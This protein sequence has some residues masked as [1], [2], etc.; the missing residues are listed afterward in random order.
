MP[1]IGIQ[2]PLTKPA[3]QPNQG[4]PGGSKNGTASAMKISIASLMPS[5]R[6]PQQSSHPQPWRAGLAVPAR[7]PR[8]A[9][10]HCPP[11]RIDAMRMGTLVRGRAGFPSDV[12]AGWEAMRMPLAGVTGRGSLVERHPGPRLVPHG[13]SRETAP[14][15]PRVPRRKPRNGYQA[16]AW[17][18]P[19][20][21]DQNPG[22]SLPP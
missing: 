2:R 9:A 10:L 20:A 15:P 11:I 13:G 5:A 4:G 18:K 1:E 19:N 3:I 22:A 12:F 14:G 21:V 16:R 8:R 17:K 7:A 6:M